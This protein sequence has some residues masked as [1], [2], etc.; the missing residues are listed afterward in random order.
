MVYWASANTASR[1]WSEVVNF[2]GKIL[3]VA[4]G[5]GEAILSAN[6]DLQ[7]LRWHKTRPYFNFLMHLRTDLYA[8]SYRRFGE[9]A[10]MSAAPELAHV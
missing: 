8:P 9:G 5:S 7:Y 4:D 3:A 2:D 1:G 6:I 10:P